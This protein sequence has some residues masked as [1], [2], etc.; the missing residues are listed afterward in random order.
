[1]NLNE[2]DEHGLIAFVMYYT[3]F[4][5]GL[6]QGLGEKQA[7]AKIG[8]PGP[9]AK[10]NGSTQ[11]GTG[12]SEEIIALYLLCNER[13]ERFVSREDHSIQTLEEISQPEISC[14]SVRSII[15]KKRPKQ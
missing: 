2:C 13:A 3:I 10:K 1:M 6:F 14:F 15:E 8:S 4:A 12:F 7:A 11:K 5:P 9:R